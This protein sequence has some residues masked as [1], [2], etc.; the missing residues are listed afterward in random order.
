MPIVDRPA[1][2]ELMPHGTSSEQPPP[3]Q[4]N[5]HDTFGVSVREMPHLK[6]SWKR[7]IGYLPNA[8][9]YGY[10]KRNRIC[11]NDINSTPLPKRPQEH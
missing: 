1:V 6:L 2:S 3:L 7:F 8:N 5:H 9:G 10:A 11:P 4:L